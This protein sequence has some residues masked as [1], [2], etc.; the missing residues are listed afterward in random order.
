[1]VNPQ[2]YSLKPQL[3]RRR[4]SVPGAAIFAIAAVVI[5]AVILSLMLSYYTI[6][7]ALAAGLA[8]ALMLLAFTQPK[9]VLYLLIFACLFSPELPITG[10]LGRASKRAL[11]IRVEDVLLVVLVVAWLVRTAGQK[12]IGLMLRTP[13]NR[14]IFIY[15]AVCIL[16]TIIGIGFGWVTEQLAAALFVVKYIQYF[17]IFF[18]VVNHIETPRELRTLITFAVL[19]YVAVCLYGYWQIPLVSEG[20][21]PSTYGEKYGEPNTLAGYL[22]FMVGICTG[23]LLYAREFTSK[24]F[25]GALALLGLVLLLYTLSRSGWLGLFGVIAVLAFLSRRRLAVVLALMSLAGL[26]VL[27]SFK[28]AWLPFH[29][30]IETR[31]QETLGQF[32]EL[33]WDPPVVLFG[34]KLDPSASERYRSYEAA[35]K[36]WGERIGEQWVP[37][38]TGSGVLGGRPFVDGQ[39]VRVIVETGLLGLIAFVVLLVAIWRDV[40]RSYRMVKTPLYRGLAIGYLAGF[41]GLLFH[42]IG[43]NTFIIVR[44]MEPFFILTGAVILLP[45]ME[46]LAARE[47]V[48]E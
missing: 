30:P 48:S 23:L 47:Q 8:I 13:L 22:L 26:L 14:P 19:A 29:A 39:Y 17:V 21:R 42:A 31:V 6:D 28:L 11:T 18:M 25:W 2:T 37:L 24:L 3:A 10:M 20:I 35:L 4:P 32:E 46:R 5:A 33:R 38:L 27:V 41:A 9:L 45:S 7:L 1:M 15:A 16:A 44:I 43:A 12:E 34:H 40:W 36:T